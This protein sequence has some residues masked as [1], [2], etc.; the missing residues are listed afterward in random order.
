VLK[1]EPQATVQQ[2]VTMFNVL[3]RIPNPNHLLSRA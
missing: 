2:N 1:V 3:V